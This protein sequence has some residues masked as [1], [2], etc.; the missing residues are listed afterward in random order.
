MLSS[1]GEITSP[2]LQA[3]AAKNQEETQHRR[4]LATISLL[5]SAYD[6]ARRPLYG[7]DP[8]TT[9]LRWWHY[10]QSMLKSLEE[11]PQP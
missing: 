8:S 5:A 7:Q 11:G 1:V 3:W 10:V 4:S 6:P 2:A 9:A